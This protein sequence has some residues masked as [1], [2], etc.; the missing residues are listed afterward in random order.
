MELFT[1]TLVSLGQKIKIFLPMLPVEEGIYAVVIA[2]QP[3]Y[4]ASPMVIT[5]SGSASDESEVQS[6]NACRP[7]EVSP[8]P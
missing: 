1:L 6:E 8:E 5:L 2:E 7:M 3:E 4:A